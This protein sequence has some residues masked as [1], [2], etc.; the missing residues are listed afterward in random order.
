MGQNGVPHTP[1]LKKREGSGPSPGGL[2]LGWG[3]NWPRQE[4]Q[5]RAQTRV[6]GD[7]QLPPQVR[8]DPP[9][10]KPRCALTAVECTRTCVCVCVCVRERR[11]IPARG[12]DGGW[13]LGAG[14]PTPWPT[15]SRAVA[16]GPGAPAG[17]TPQGLGPSSGT[18]PPPGPLLPT[19]PRGLQC[20]AGRRLCTWRAPGPEGGLG[21]GGRG[22]PALPPVC[23]GRCLLSKCATW[24]P[25]LG[26]WGPPA[27]RLHSRGGGRRRVGPC[28][29]V[30]RSPG[31]C[32]PRH[33]VLT[34]VST[35]PGA[36]GPT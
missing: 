4:A 30:G 17:C 15:P 35:S 13:L 11:C 26:V 18:D 29:L 24:T 31:G 1:T 7:F 36:A 12:P 3:H 22:G 19:E 28:G 5:T 34:S 32:R 14:W 21:G 9:L 8:T 23:R 33:G 25:W 27:S 6:H 10:G 20:Q 16:P 2:S